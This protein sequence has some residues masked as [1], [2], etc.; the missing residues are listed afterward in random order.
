MLGPNEVTI[1]S[2][3]ALPAVLGPGT[4]CTK[5]GWYDTLKPLIALNTTR[6][7]G[8]HDRRR[9]IWNRGFGQKGTNVNYRLLVNM[10]TQWLHRSTS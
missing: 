9:R 5:T 10:M 6:D 1:F 4:K 2:P 8:L 3:D 7:K